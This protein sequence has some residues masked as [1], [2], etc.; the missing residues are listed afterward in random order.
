MASL[1]PHHD[2]PHADEHAPAEL[3]HQGKKKE[4]AEEEEELDICSIC[5]ETLPRWPSLNI[6]FTRFTC[7]GKGMHDACHKELRK[8]SR[9]RNCPMCRGPA[10]ASDK[11]AHKQALRWAKKGKAWAILVV[12]CNFQ[13]GR[14]VAVSKRMAR[15]WYEKAAKEGHPQAQFTLGVMHANGECGLPK[16]RETARLWYEKAAEQ[17]HSDA[18]CNLGL[19]HAQGDG[20]LPVSKEKAHLWYKMAAELGHPAAQYNLGVMHEYAIGKIPMSKEKARLWYEKAAG[21]GY[22]AAQRYLASLH[23]KGGGDLPVSMELAFFWMARACDQGDKQSTVTLE[24]AKSKCFSCGK[25]GKLDRCPKCK[26]AY[27]CSRD[28]QAV[29]WKSGHKAACKQIRRKQQSAD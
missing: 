29:A 11:A 5:L 3:H 28:C 15:L 24:A 20:G 18:Q 17:G 22:I 8:S 12:G 2:G 1:A 25:I 13:E 21:Q 14:G 9:S 19:M 23:S 27:Y 16:P 10:P 26:C 7:C 6:Q 4:A